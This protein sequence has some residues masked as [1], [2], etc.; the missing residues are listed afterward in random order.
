LDKYP[1]LKADIIEYIYNYKLID[2]DDAIE[3]TNIQ[4]A[5]VATEE[6]SNEY[7]KTKDEIGYNSKGSYVKK[8][9]SI[10]K[11]VLFDS[12]YQCACNPKHKT[13]DTP[14]GNPY[15]EG[16]HLIPC[17]PDKSK[18]YESKSKLD[19]E[20]NIVCI[21]PNCHKAV[22]LGD[23]KVKIDIL[24]KLYNFQKEKLDSANLDIGIEELLK[25][26]K[27]VQK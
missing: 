13:F 23:L 15:M 5:K 4:R 14:S 21:C 1:Q 22:H 10:S 12:N 25:E 19:R 9:S 8:K 26:Y 27:V 11:K 20:E 6:E 3:Q 17:T 16:H 7:N 24:K 2:I 18:K